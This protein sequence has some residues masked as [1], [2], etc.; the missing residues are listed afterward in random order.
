[1]S[2]DVGEIR[3]L[4]KTL[5]REAFVARFPW[6]FLATGAGLEDLAAGYETVSAAAPPKSTPSDELTAVYPLVK[7]AGAQQT[8]VLIGRSR[9]SDVVLSDASVSKVHASLSLK[10]NVAVELTDLGSHNGTFI[11]GRKMAPKVP[12]PISP[13][14]QLDFGTVRMRL[15]D[16]M[17]L[18]LLLH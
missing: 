16:A 4:A 6:Q 11:F 12:H 1:M 18:Y 3:Q 8:R 15:V 9:T 17:T 14:A 5:T 10:N 7:G 2:L 13:G